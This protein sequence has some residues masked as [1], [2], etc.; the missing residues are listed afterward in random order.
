MKPGLLF[1]KLFLGNALLM[2]ALL[3][4]LGWITIAT[5][6]KFNAQ[7]L[8]EHLHRQAATVVQAIGGRLDTGQAADLDRFVEGLRAAQ[9][10][11]I[12]YTLISADG[13]VI[14]D[15]EVDPSTMEPH[16]A[17][18][19]V[20]EALSHGWG[21]D[22]RLSQT[23]ARATKYVAVRVGGAEHPAGVVRVAMPLRSITARS[24]AEHKPIWMIAFAGL[25]AVMLLALG[26]AR[27]WSQP[28]RRITLTAQSISRGDLS[29]RVPVTGRDEIGALARSLNQMRDHLAAHLETID[30]QRRVLEA[31]LAQISEGVVVTGPQGRIVLINPAAIR[32]LSLS[33]T[34]GG[35]EQFAG[36]AVEECI[37]QH[38]LQQALLRPGG[39]AEPECAGGA[40][41]LRL[42]IESPNGPLTLMGRVCDVILPG[43]GGQPDESAKPIVGRLLVLTDITELARMIQIKADFAANTS[44]ELRTPLSAIRGAVETLL[45]MDFADEPASA[46]KFLGVI[47][48]HSSL[49]LAM[50]TD[51]LNLSRLESSQNRFEPTAVNLAEFL[52]D[53][54]AQYSDILSSKSLHWQASIEKPLETIVVN[55][56]LL[57]LTLENLVDNAIKFTE[58]GGRVSVICT[59]N[60]EQHGRP[61]GVSI[62]VVD[63]GCGIPE[64]E[65]GRVFERFYQVARARSG[66][67]RGTGLGLSIVRH[68]VAAMNGTVSL[69]SRVGEGTCVTI[70]IPQPAPATA[71]PGPP[72]FA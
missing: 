21:E 63:T 36:R 18:K 6:D 43:A 70:V 71:Q 5:V 72:I 16:G 31:L 69:R 58:A 67:A 14:A 59:Q 22:T 55:P 23:L 50:I 11:D 29:A 9:T 62:D 46:R 47:D 10:G 8:T 24:R 3:V 42:Q 52:E 34:S 48:R 12:R 26:L 4:T 15:S 65:Q 27:L 25:L 56:Y 44:H 38:E 32:L 60:G 2:A 57:R 45:D 39:G 17:R 28:I 41:E 66:T 7:D 68:A 30:K 54:H 51:L 40:Q 1:W 35:R 19:E 37:S 33:P 20:Q 49:M 13:R 53:L 64:E 61:G